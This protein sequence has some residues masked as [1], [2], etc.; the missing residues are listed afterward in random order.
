MG[1]QRCKVVLCVS[2]STLDCMSS[3]YIELRKADPFDRGIHQGR[4]KPTHTQRRIFDI[5]A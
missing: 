5:N 1:I 2:Y 3:V 4:L